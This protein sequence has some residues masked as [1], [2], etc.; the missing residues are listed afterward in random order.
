MKVQYV[1][2]ALDYSGYGEANRHDIGALLSAGVQLSLKCPSYVHDLADFGRLGA[3]IMDLQDVEIPYYFKIVHTTPDQFK[4]YYEVDKY[5]IGRVIWET[6]KLPPDFVEASN[7]MDE[8]W[9]ASE[10]GKIAAERAGVTKPIFVIPEAI[11]TELDIDSVEPYKSDPKGYV[12]YSIF[13]WTDRK[14][15]KALLSAYWKEFGPKDRVA[16]VL[17]TFMTNFSMAKKREIEHE[18]NSIKAQLN[19]EYYAPVYVYKE[20]MDRHQIYRLH[21]SFDC[22]VSAHRGEGWGIPQMEAMML[23][24]PI[25]STN[26]CGIHEYLKHGKDALLVNYELIPIRDAAFNSQWYRGDQHWGEVNAQH[27]Q[28]CMRWAYDNQGAAAKIGATARK[29]VINKFSLPVVGK[30]MSDRLQAIENERWSN[31]Q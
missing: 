22:F 15:P 21:K 8:I 3:T 17:K 11:D 20:L 4:K 14:N 29:T 6:D 10:Y 2:P 5:N 30:I 28:N 23:E 25:I 24:N 27:L 16:L 9:V 1:G 19:L 12:F 26:L 13:E 7:V 18:I 31:E